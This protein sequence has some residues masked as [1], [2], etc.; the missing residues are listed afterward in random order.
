[1]IDGLDASTT[2]EATGKHRH[3]HRHLMYDG[4]RLDDDTFNIVVSA[5]PVRS[6]GIS[7]WDEEA[8]HE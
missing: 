3:L 1:M 2:Y 6:T 8:F 7:L 5:A 4:E